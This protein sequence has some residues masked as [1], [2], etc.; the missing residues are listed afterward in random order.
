LDETLADA[1]GFHLGDLFVNQCEE[2]VSILDKRDLDGEKRASDAAYGLA[3]QLLGALLNVE[4]GAE[5]CT[6]AN[7]AIGDALD[8]LEDINFE[9]TGSFLSPQSGGNLRAQALSLA[10]KLDAYNNGDLC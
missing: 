3:A 4:A 6:A 9:G 8:L 10:S 2:A 1:G 7:D 5:S